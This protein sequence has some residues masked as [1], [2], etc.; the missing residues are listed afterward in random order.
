MTA[1]IPDLILL[2]DKKFSI[3]GV[4]ENDLFDPAHFDLHPF[5]SIT[6]CWRGY[7]CMYKTLYNK[8]LFHK[9][10]VNLHQQ[11]PEI[12]GVGPIF[13]KATFNNTYNDLHMSVD[14]T[15]E[16]FA[17]DGLI[18]KLCVHMGVHPA[19]KYETVYELVI[20]NRYVLDTKDVSEQLAQ[21]REQTT[22]QPLDHPKK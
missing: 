2:Q 11:G 21:L 7:I 1:Q 14:F 13:S 16:I 3:V 20:L 10:E 15:G 9:L 18:R 12:N 5:Q 4:N 19:W 8:M 22:R 17:A 6:G